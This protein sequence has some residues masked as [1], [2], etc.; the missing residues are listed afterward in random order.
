MVDLPEVPDQLETTITFMQT[1]PNELLDNLLQNYQKP[2]DIFGESGLLK[3]L[4]KAL[5]ERALPTAM[6]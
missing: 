1:I 6:Q 3:Q 5:I 4:T 2:E